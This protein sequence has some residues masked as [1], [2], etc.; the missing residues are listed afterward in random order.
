MVFNHSDVRYIL[1]S[2]L[3]YAQFL[4]CNNVKKKLYHIIF[5][6]KI[7]FFKSIYNCYYGF[8][9]CDKYFMYIF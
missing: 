6:M 2:I 7:T 3:T 1:F 4:L 5:Y 8:I 9:T